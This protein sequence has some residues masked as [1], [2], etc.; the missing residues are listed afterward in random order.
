MCTPKTG[1]LH[2]FVKSVGLTLM[3]FRMSP[4]EKNL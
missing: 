3:F 1:K 2:R 4:A